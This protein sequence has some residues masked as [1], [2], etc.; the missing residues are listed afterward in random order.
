MGRHIGIW[1]LIGLS[2]T[3]PASGVP[4]FNGARFRQLR[5]DADLTL[6]QVARRVGGSVVT[7]TVRVRGGEATDGVVGL[8]GWGV[9]R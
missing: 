1:C 2:P 4:K 5:I 8:F 7:Q 3:T 9:V 6:A